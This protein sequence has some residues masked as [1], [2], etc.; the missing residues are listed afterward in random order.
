MRNKAA[1]ILSKSATIC[2]VSVRSSSPVAGK[3]LSLGAIEGSQRPLLG[4]TT[5][6]TWSKID[7]FVALFQACSS[8]KYTPRLR[9]ARGRIYGSLWVQKNSLTRKVITARGRA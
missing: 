7:R 3:G 8:A 6:R 5:C 9:F 2:C 4:N 1:Q